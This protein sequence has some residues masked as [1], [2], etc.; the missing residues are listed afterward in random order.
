[1]LRDLAVAQMKLILG[2]RTTQDAN[3]V[4]QLQ[5]IQEQLETDATLPWFLRKNG[6]GITTSPGDPYINKP[7]DYIREWDEDP[8]YLVFENEEGVYNVNLVKDSESFLR[9]RYS[10]NEAPAGYVEFAD[11]WKL[12]PTP[13][14]AYTINYSY[15][16][17]GLPLTTNI[18]NEWLKYN[19]DVLIGR[20]GLILATGLR[21][22]TAME[23]FGALAKAG[24]E[25]LVSQSTAQEEAGARRVMGGED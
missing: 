4:T 15:Y 13:T 23:I 5:L 10:S 1:M 21:D 14:E 16:G 12:V 20:A 2:F 19:A 7:V 17:R 11:K 24:T 3:C 6:L 9:A 22:K 18:E 8:F 25:K